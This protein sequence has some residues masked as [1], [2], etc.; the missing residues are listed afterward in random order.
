VIDI[1]RP[2]SVVELPGQ[3]AS[4]SGG[5]AITATPAPVYPSVGS[6]S[7]LPENTL[8]AFTQE[9]AKKPAWI[10]A[11]SPSQWHGAGNAA[12]LVIITH[13]NFKDAAAALA[14]QRASQGLATKVIDVQDAYDE[15]S[16]GAKDPQAIRDLLALAKTT[17]KQA[18]RF[19]LLLGDATSDPRNY[20]G[21][22][23]T[24]FVP[25]KMVPL[26]VL[27]SA[28]DDWFVDFN[29]T[30]FPQMAIGRIPVQTVAEAATVVGKLVQYDAT[31]AGAGW[32]GTATFVSD[33]NDPELRVAF[34]DE[35]HQ[36]E[37]QVPTALARNEILVGNMDS[38]SAHS[39]VLSALN[40]GS[41][42]VTYVGH[43][44][45]ASWSTS[46]LFTT[47]DAAALSNGAQLPV[48]STLNCLNGLFEDPSADSLGE[49]MLK[50][51]AGGAVAVLASSALTDP[52][53][54]LTLGTHFYNA[55]FNSAGLSVGQA[56]M[57]AKTSDVR[58]TVRK[59]F[60]LLGDPSMKLR[61]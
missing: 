27:K 51:P 2:D 17:W 19:V 45:D 24:D 10:Q 55:L 16:Y 59:S 60:L 21:D 56:L 38:T 49:A 18:P 3:V 12:D 36:M 53:P 57:A 54:Q 7:P 61:R 11:N 35:T 39:A 42:L 5:Y 58:D 15:F 20:L 37:Q 43:G 32:T 40:A 23:M 52:E 41:L 46:N 14:A 31:P 4:L 44:T 13:Q 26:E 25:T 28:S 48:V 47:T 50:A 33:A 29:D 22:T 6:Q 9:Q 8:F 34:V 1:S 30:G